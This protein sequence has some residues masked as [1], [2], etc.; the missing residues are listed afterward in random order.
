[1][2]GIALEGGGAKGAF[3]VGAIRALYELGIKPD[4]VAGTS[5]GAINGAMIAAGDL[6][7]LE[8][9]WTS[10]GIEDMIQG[11]VELVKRMVEFDF[12]RD[13]HKMRGFLKDTIKHG[14]LDVTPF[15]T[16]LKEVVDE[17]KI[18][19]SK[20]AYG[21][22]TLSLSDLKPVELFVEDIPSGRLHDYILASANF[23]AFKREELD[24]KKMLDG[25]FFD[26]LPINMLIGRGCDEVIAIRLYGMG[27]IRKV[28][29][30]K[31]IKITYINPSEDLGRTLA[32]DAQK[33]KHNIQMGYFDAMRV[34]KGIKSKYYYV[35]HI[36]EDSEVLAVLNQIPDVDIVAIGKI[37]DVDKPP[38]RLLFEE[39]FPMLCDILKVEKCHS[40][41]EIILALYEYLAKNIGIER[42][43]WLTFAQLI[44]KVH[45]AYG[46]EN[47]EEVLSIDDLTKHIMAWV[48]NKGIALLPHR[49]KHHL[50][51]QIFYTFHLSGLWGSVV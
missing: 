41:A 40:Y 6:D 42:F 8:S 16:R 20:I 39:L 13:Y 51:L 5:I 48:P 3:Q 10:A 33:A 17:E 38:K 27:R 32:I 49:I 24:E 25:A 2:L 4:V 1:M 37:L 45:Q 34:M 50:I 7:L 28:K 26:N 14:G 47:I 12:K 18:R 44:E 29:N 15:R 19:Q 46:E 43:E 30:K 22:V 11:D 35:T 36:P 31:G 9:I 23:P 21:L